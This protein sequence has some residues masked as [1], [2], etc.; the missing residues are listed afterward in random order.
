VTEFIFYAAVSSDG[1]IAGPEGDMAW[2]EKY[3]TGGDDYGFFELMSSC[4]AVLMGAE[5][6][7]FELQ[8][9]GNEPRMLPTFVLTSN[10]QR[11]DGVTDPNVYFLGGEI[12]TVTAAVHTQLVDQIKDP[13]TLVFVFGGASV[14]KQM[15]AADLLDVVRL[16]VT[17]DVLGGGVPLFDLTG[18]A[19]APANATAPEASGID[20]IA[21]ALSHF[22]Q[23]N[24]RS[25]SSG[26]VE[27]I[28]ARN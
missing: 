12:T 5:T 13:N 21:A 8:A 15:L 19:D 20:P 25:F 6:F 1:Y 7:D 18:E 27:K 16:F 3:L 23:V 24:Q 14:V 9:I 22:T 17:P 28:F 10:P 4:S 2:A 26:L 11:F